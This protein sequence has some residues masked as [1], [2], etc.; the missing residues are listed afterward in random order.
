M[1]REEIIQLATEK[2]QLALEIIEKITGQK[3]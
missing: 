3:A 2:Q 1:S